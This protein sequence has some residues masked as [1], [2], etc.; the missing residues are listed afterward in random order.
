MGKSMLLTLDVYISAARIASSDETG[1]ESESPIQPGRKAICNAHT[2]LIIDK[3]R[4]SIKVAVAKLD[5][6]Q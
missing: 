1:E 6:Y 2:K 5:Q 4:Y 3:D